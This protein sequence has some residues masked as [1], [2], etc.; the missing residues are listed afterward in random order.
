MYD[1][2]NHHFTEEQ[3]DKDLISVLKPIHERRYR[4][5][6]LAVLHDVPSRV[7]DPGY[8][9]EGSKKRKERTFIIDAK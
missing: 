9:E 2:G 3:E 1:V 7:H 8:N 4:K 6:E 5:Y